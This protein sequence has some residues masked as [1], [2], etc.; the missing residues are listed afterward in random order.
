MCAQAHFEKFN[1]RFLQWKLSKPDES[2]I[3]SIRA[4]GVLSPILV[5]PSDSKFEILDGR[6]RFMASKA[7]GLSLIPYY[8]I[9]AKCSVSEL[10]FNLQIEELL[11]STIIKLRYLTQF[12]LALD[13]TNL[14][15]L[16]LPFY[17]HIKK[18]I[19][20]IVCLSDLAHIFLKDKGFSLKELVN[21]TH[22]SKTA[23][24]RLL[25]DDKL[26]QFTKRTFDES[27][28]MISALMKRYSISLEAL[29]TKTNYLCLLSEELTPQQRQKKWLN[30]LRSEISP[31]LIQTQN[32]IDE[33]ISSTSIPATINYDRTL[34]NTG[35]SIQSHVTSLNEVTELSSA[36]TTKDV[37]Q[38]LQL[39]MDLT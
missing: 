14:S 23:F 18:D 28:S 1:D 12:N 6:K 20:R 17:S 29:L 11:S 16:N 21:L 34:E 8:L 10:I 26:F 25:I 37:Q 27:L 19:D 9:N 5:I 39:I 3:K 7:L 38:N 36:L 2:L 31:V 32:K 33:L 15:K 24:N 35:I 13:V 22:Y 30:E 4:Y